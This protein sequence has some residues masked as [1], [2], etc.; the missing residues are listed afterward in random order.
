MCYSYESSLKAF[1]I[2]AT[3]CILL[4]LRNKGTDRWGALF[5]GLFSL[6]QLFEAGLWKRLYDTK[7]N[8]YLTTS[9]MLLQW[10]YPTISSYIAWKYTKSPQFYYITI[11]ASVALLYTI[12]RAITASEGQIHSIIDSEQNLQWIDNDKQGLVLGDYQLLFG[13]IW[14]AAAALPLLYMDNTALLALF[15]GGA[16]LLS[17]YL[18]P[19]YP[20]S[21]WCY[22][23]TY[24][25]YALL[26]F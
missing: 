20:G 24:L 26:L 15:F 4:W 11:A 12:Y 1:I 10:I 14:F 9:I 23:S 25:G 8:Q 6:T 19:E 16:Y 7:A 21:L 22:Y 5:I 18:N 17:K 13:I 3:S 2:A